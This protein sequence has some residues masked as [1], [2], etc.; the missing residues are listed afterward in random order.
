MV[1][2]Q[3]FVA[4]F[5]FKP[6]VREFKVVQKDYNLIEVLVALEGEANDTDIAAITD[7][8]QQVMGEDCKVLFK[9]VDEVPPTA[10]GKY[11]Y[12]FSEVPSS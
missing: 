7:K 6:W 2:S 4:L 9:F 12:T 5:F 1:H 10:S 3:F 8:I 11:L